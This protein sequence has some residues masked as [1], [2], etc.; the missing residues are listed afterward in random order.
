MKPDPFQNNRPVLTMVMDNRNHSSDANNRRTYAMLYCDTNENVDFNYY[1]NF[2][3]KIDN[4]GFFV[5]VSWPKCPLF[6]INVNDFFVLLFYFPFSIWSSEGR[7]FVLRAT[8][9]Q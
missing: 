9:P 5:Y 4:D 6:S 2:D 1:G 7:H 3:K 8:T